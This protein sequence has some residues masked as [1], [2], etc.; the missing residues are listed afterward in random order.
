MAELREALFPEAVDEAESQFVDEVVV[1]F[2]EFVIRL[3]SGVVIF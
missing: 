3:A 2:P 1:E